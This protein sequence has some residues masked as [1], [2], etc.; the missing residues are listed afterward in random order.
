MDCA[1][2]LAEAADEGGQLPHDDARLLIREALARHPDIQLDEDEGASSAILINGLAS[3]SINS[4]KS[5]G[6]SH[7]G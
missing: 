5:I 7:D 6:W 2:R 3:S 1:D 4:S